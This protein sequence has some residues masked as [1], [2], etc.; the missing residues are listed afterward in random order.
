M[1]TNTAIHDSD[2][3]EAIT[4]YQVITLLLDGALE[5]IDQAIASVSEGDLD[6]AS[7]LVQKTMKIVSGL[8][9]SL[10]LNQG[11]DIATNLEALYNYI[12]TRLE[13]IGTDAPLTTLTEVKQLLSEVHSGWVGISDEVS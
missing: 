6:E 12:L 7:V 13:S 8:R 2:T 4:P 3:I 9:E 5:R 10:N 1:S 11:G